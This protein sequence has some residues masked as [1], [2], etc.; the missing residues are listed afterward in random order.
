MNEFEEAMLKRKITIPHK[1]CG[2]T[3]RRLSYQS[4]E[5]GDYWHLIKIPYFCCDK[6]DK[7]VKLAFEVT[8]VIK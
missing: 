3:F 6:C 2:G 5:K 8:E 7:V 4:Y 1:R